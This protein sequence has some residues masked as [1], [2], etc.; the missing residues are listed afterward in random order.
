MA[1]S[2]PVTDDRGITMSCFECTR[3]LWDSTSYQ[4]VLWFTAW[5]DQTSRDAGKSPANDLSRPLQFTVDFTNFTTAI[6]T[7]GVK[8]LDEADAALIAKVPAKT[9]NWFDTTDF[10]KAAKIPNR[11]YST[12]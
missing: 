10:S 8:T 6:Q 12:V 9:G 1:I 7:Q 4:A 3:I 11:T 5:V 2:L